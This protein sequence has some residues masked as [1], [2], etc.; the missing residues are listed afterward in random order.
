MLLCF[1]FVEVDQNSSDAAIRESSLCRLPLPVWH[2]SIII[3]A[4]SLQREP[5][6]KDLS[7][8][9]TTDTIHLIRSLDLRS[10][11]ENLSSKLYLN[12]HI[13]LQAQVQATEVNHDA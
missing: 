5:I 3:S 9:Q 11:S 12:L 2:A 8:V 7:T 10:C 6:D 1:G 13:R 4:K